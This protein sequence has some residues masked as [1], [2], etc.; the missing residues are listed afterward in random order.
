MKLKRESGGVL[1]ATL[2]FVIILSTAASSILALSL[3]SYRL[4]MRNDLRAQAKAVAETEM[5]W[6]YYQFMNLILGGSDPQQ[7]PTLLATNLPCDTTPIP[8][9]DRSPYLEAHRTAGWIVRRSVVFNQY[10]EGV[11]PSTGKRGKITYIDVRVEVLPPASSAFSGTF[12]ERVGRYF[13]C[14]LTSIFQNAIF[15]QGDL[16]MAPGGN[17]TITGDI[18]ANGSIYMGAGRD[19]LGNLGTLTVNNQVRYLA[20]HYF[21][22]D[23]NGNTVLRKP[24]TPPGGTLTAPVFGTSEADQ[25][26]EM[27]TQQNLLGGIDADALATARPDLFPSVNDVYRSLIAPPPDDA[28]PQEYPNYPTSGGLGDDPTISAQ[29]M[30]NRAALRITVEA[31]GSVHFRK[32]GE[33][34][35]CDSL[36]AG[37]VATMVSVRDQREGC[38]VYVYPIE[39][40]MLNTRLAANYPT[41]DG[42]V[43]VNLKKGDSVYPAAIRLEN[44]ATTPT[45]SNLGFSVATNGGVYVVG[46]Y[47]TTPKGTDAG[48]NPIYNPAMI[49][50]DAVTVLSPG[51]VDGHSADPIG[52]RIATGGGTTINAGVL[53]GNVSA[54]TTQASGGAQNLLRYLEDWTGIDVLIQGSLGR[55]FDSKYYIRPWQQPGSIYIQP[56]ARNFTYDSSFQTQPPPDSPSTTD[57]TRGGFFNW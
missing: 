8:T 5:D 57:F 31:D 9:T 30:Y 3:F 40:D 15:F 39:V 4:A 33:S 7:T 24:G 44:A 23:S 51:W 46:D 55:L 25:V 21:N 13:S 12:S 52:S 38:D 37:V 56:H 41:Y 27:T 53:T 43:Y 45:V 18:S 1:L 49:M 54:T 32:K 20:G 19:Q 42:T 36:F 10:K 2:V 22:Q 26:Q 47:N 11:I 35:D 6:T 28:T 16:E 14:A 48:G 17:M 50:G 34:S 29:R